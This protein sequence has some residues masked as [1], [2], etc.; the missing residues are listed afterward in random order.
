MGKTR[1]CGGTCH[2]AKKPNCR[3]WCGGV[4]HGSAGELARVEFAAAFKCHILP[5]TEKAFDQVTGQRDLF[6]D[7]TEGDVW[8]QRISEAL[9]ARLSSVGQRR[10]KRG[11]TGPGAASRDA[12]SAGH[13][14]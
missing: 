5:T 9:A 11:V 2:K 12:V 1:V 7:G 4:F 10:R 13:T 8:K 3:C 14:T 6:T